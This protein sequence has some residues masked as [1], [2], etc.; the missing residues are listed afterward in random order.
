MIGVMPDDGVVKPLPP[1][2]RVFD[3]TVSKL[4]ATGHEIVDWS[5]SLNQTCI[6]IQVSRSLMTS[7]SKAYNGRTSTTPQ[8]EA[9]TSELP[10]CKVESH[11]RSKHRPS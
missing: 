2:A 6:A 7:T 11:S 1:I 5:N 9:K 8:T 4:R 10:C 3:E